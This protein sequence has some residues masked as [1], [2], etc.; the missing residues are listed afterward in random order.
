MSYTVSENLPGTSRYFGTYKNSVLIFNHNYLSMFGIE[1]VK[2]PKQEQIETFFFQAKLLLNQMKAVTE[3]QER[4]RQ[5]SQLVPLSN[6]VLQSHDQLKKLKMH[7]QK[8]FRESS[9]DI[10][11][12]GF[13]NLND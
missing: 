3:S 6:I 10:L 12:I 13:I 2:R 11:R 8:F 4:A 5:S 7:F 1:R 9:I